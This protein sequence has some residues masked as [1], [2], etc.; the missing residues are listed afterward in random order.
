M[1]KFEYKKVKFDENELATNILNELGEEGWE[2]MNVWPNNLCLFKRE[3]PFVNI[4]R[5]DKQL[6]QESYKHED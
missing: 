5:T 3:I 2:L 6:L 4:K 1:K